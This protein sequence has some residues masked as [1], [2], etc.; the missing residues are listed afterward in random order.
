MYTRKN[1]EKKSRENEKRE[2][3]YTLYTTVELFKCWLELTRWRKKTMMMNA[4][5]TGA[6]EAWQMYEKIQKY[7]DDADEVWKIL[8]YSI[9]KTCNL[10]CSY[11]SPNHTF[12]IPAQLGHSRIKLF[13]Y[14]IKYCKRASKPKII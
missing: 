14:A 3:Y 4:A 7:V 8:F 13:R 12:S 5:N 1:Q 10:S 6:N 9:Y 2:R 11:V